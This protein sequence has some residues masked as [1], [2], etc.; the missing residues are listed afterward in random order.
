MSSM[1]SGETRL[2][3]TW[4]CFLLPEFP[5]HP[6]FRRSEICSGA[7][8][9][10]GRVSANSKSLSLEASQLWKCCLLETLARILT[11]WSQVVKKSLH[12]M[13]IIFMNLLLLSRASEAQFQTERKNV[14]LPSLL[15]MTAAPTFT[16]LDHD[17]PKVSQ[18]KD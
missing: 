2:R 17:S 13:Y 10:N 16:K 1:S 4:C 18:N 9:L 3:A 6:D 15:A 12:Y 5:G 7:L 14:E 11:G 8:V